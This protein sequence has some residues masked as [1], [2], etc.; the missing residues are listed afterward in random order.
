MPRCSP[1]S[2]GISRLIVP[3]DAAATYCALG[4]ALAPLR[5]DYVH[6]VRALLD[7]A[8]VA[9]L[10]RA[11]GRDPRAGRGLARRER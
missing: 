9:E 3:P 5:R 1:T 2:W 7:D 8:T 4:A 6:S 10:Q 11:G